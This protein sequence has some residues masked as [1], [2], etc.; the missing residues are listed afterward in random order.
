[1]QKPMLHRPRR[2]RMNPRIRDMVRET[3]VSV[4]DLIYPMFVT[5]EENAETPIQ[6]MPGCFQYGLG[7]IGD[8]CKRVEEAGVPAVILFGLPD[9]KDAKGSSS[10]DPHGVIAKAIE[11]IKKSCT[12]LVV[13]TDVCMCEYTSHGHCGVLE[14]ESILNDET[15]E[16]LCKEAVM[17]ANA[18][19]DVIAPSD[20]MDG[21]IAALRAAL[22]AAGHIYTPIMSYAVKYAS[23]FYGPFRDAVES[24]PSFGDRR[25]HQMDPPNRL[26]AL[27]QARIDV[28]A[29]AD[30]LMV[31]PGLPYLDIIRDLKNTLDL[32]LAAYNVSGEY[33]MIKAAAEKGWLDEKRAVLEIM[34]SFKRAG[35]DMVLTYHALDVARWLQED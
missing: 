30:I 1:M 16:V 17:H 25:S 13:M 24:A 27:R 8:A 18:G 26:E 31:K 32:P 3:H 7:K 22:D 34:N 6:S 29:G 28:E 11:A 35:V 9:H 20:M 2:L 21:R 19:S 14:G 33:S 5:C 4:D 23:G 10:Y 12:S 15:V